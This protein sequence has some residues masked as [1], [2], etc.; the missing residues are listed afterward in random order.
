MC[1]KC[2]QKPL[3]EKGQVKPILRKKI[4]RKITC[5]SD[6]DIPTLIGPEH[7]PELNQTPS[8]VCSKHYFLKYLVKFCAK[9]NKKKRFSRIYVFIFFFKLKITEG[10]KCH[11]LLFSHHGVPQR[12]PKRRS[13]GALHT[14]YTV[15]CLSFFLCSRW[16]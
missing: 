9:K 15:L 2:A 7:Y 4:S 3:S 14:I 6:A 8:S 12:S 11:H 1:K 5:L 13:I 16:H 10:G